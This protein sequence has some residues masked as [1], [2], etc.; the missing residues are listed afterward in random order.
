MTPIEEINKLRALLLPIA[1]PRRG[2]NEEWMDRADFAEAIQA[3][4]ELEDLEPL[5]PETEAL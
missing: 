1:Y 5:T 4:C 2:T 3:A